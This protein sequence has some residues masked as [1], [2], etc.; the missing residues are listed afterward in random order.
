MSFRKNIIDALCEYKTRVSES[1]QDEFSR[2]ARIFLSQCMLPQCQR[3][4]VSR[5]LSVFDFAFRSHLSWDDSAGHISI[6]PDDDGDAG[7][8]VHYRGHL[9]LAAEANV[10]SRCVAELIYETDDFEYFG[11]NERPRLS[12]KARKDMGE[13]VGGYTISYLPDGSLLSLFFTYDDLLRAEEL[14]VGAGNREFWTGPHRR[15]M[16]RKTLIICSAKRWQELR[17]MKSGKDFDM[18]AA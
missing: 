1:R 8:Y 14:G 3:F 17:L 12:R 18:A 4:T 16:Q 5:L 9:V 15:D 10:I 7:Y 13:V 2:E 6:A 11:E